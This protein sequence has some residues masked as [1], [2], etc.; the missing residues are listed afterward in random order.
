MLTIGFFIVMAYWSHTLAKKPNNPG[1]V[2]WHHFK[3]DVEQLLNQ[4]DQ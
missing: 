1:F 4:E 3:S 2:E